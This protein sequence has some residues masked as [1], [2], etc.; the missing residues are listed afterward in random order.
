MTTRRL[1][2]ARRGAVAA[3]TVAAA[4]VL[5]ACGSDDSAGH[6]H[7]DMGGTSSA[8]ATQGGHNA[9]DV[10]FARDMIPHH[11]QAVAMADL[12]P[13]RAA[14]Q[15][16]KALAAKIKQAQD[17]EIATMSGWLAGWGEKVPSP[18]ASGMK[19]MEGMDHSGHSM[20]GMMSEADMG[21]LEKLSGTAFDT[22]FLEM[23]IGHHEGAIEMAKAEQTKGASG[24]AKQLAAAI[25]T[26][27]SAE[28]A[29]MNQML[30][31]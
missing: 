14:S 5:A 19:G 11:R 27:Q 25:V 9:Q 30:G 31:K 28:I 1:T 20:P 10:A 22:A 21:T 8:S 16:V 18:D 15:D 3:A 17:P 26:A 13:T 2:A 4:L 29:Q 7:H 23:M 24:P 6:A 12:A